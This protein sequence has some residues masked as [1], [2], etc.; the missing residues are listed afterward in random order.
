MEKKVAVI[1]GASSGVGRSTA[2]HLSK[3]GFKVA[4]CAR[5]KNLLDE[6]SA[7]IKEQGGEVISNVCDMTVWSE[8]EEFF[9]LV[10]DKFKRIDVLVNNVGAGIRYT[11]FEN[12]SI[13]EIELGVK[14]NVL[15]VMYGTKAAIP[16]MKR[17]KGGNII[18]IS[19]ILGKMARS[20]LAVYTAGKHAVEGFS[21]S[22]WNE[23]KGYGIKVTVLAPAMINTEWAKKAGIKNLFAEGKMLE[24]EDIARMVEFIINLP[25]HYN[26]WNM[27]IMA[28][29]QTIDPL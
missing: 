13:E 16:V 22:L 1:T 5:R 24:P 12:M 7:E 14:V 8:V 17:Q 11:E 27:D 28:L 6:L 3:L 10:I 15:S 25:D 18:N 9:N 2:L 4:V 23:L 19:S 21:K 20:K 29:S 26:I